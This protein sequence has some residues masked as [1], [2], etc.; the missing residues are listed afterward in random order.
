[1][2][3]NVLLLNVLQRGLK[4]FMLSASCEAQQPLIY[5]HPRCSPILSKGKKMKTKSQS[6]KRTCFY[7]LLSLGLHLFLIFQMCFL[8]FLQSSCE[9]IFPVCHLVSEYHPATTPCCKLTADDSGTNAAPASMCIQRSILVSV[10]SQQILAWMGNDTH[11]VRHGSLVK[12]TTKTVNPWMPARVNFSVSGTFLLTES[13]TTILNCFGLCWG[14]FMS[15]QT[16]TNIM[17]SWRSF[18][19]AHMVAC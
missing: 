6:K 10:R 8:S 19:F 5:T 15:T 3:A 14:H 2:W 13:Y 4:P 16:Q 9:N 7:H 1:M 12:H 17:W 11:G 18:M